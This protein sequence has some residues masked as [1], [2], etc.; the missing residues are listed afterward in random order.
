MKRFFG[1]FV[2]I[3][4]LLSFVV[5]SDNVTVY[6][7]YSS[8]CSHCANVA[9]SGVLEDVNSM[10]KVEVT[11]YNVLSEGRDKFFEFTDR[12]NLSR[13]VPLAVIEKDGN[14]SYLRGDSPI[15]NSLG[16]AVRG[17]GVD[18]GEEG[19]F[20]EI[21]SYLGKKF[22]ENFNSETGRLSFVGLL[23]LILAA[24]VDSINPCAFGVLIFLMICLLNLGSSKRALRYGLI[25][26]FVVFLVYFIAGF[27]VF[28][29][30]QSFSSITKLVYVLSGILVLGL[31]L[32]QF[33]D[34]FFPHIGPT[35]QIS[36]KAK[37]LIEKIIQMGTLPAMILLGIVVSLFELPCT[38]G[39]YLAIITLLSK[40][41][42]F[43]VLYL[44]IY[45]LIFI[46]PL[47]ILTSLIYKGTDA[48]ILQKWTQKE[49]KWMKFAAGIVLIALGLYIL[50]F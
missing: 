8:G 26:T 43:P 50:I 38:G 17:E 14:F 41:G 44:L 37:P 12:F 30:L 11:K 1:L 5:A 32:W 24:L 21:S 42:A 18:E 15:I 16:N 46:L 39:V 6:Y 48:H 31:G 22:E 20:S 9:S 2:L 49:R 10:D 23:I 7:F 28:H 29:A 45:N 27:G 19:F 35:L 13:G 36:P 34:V 3:V 47:I 33:K 40:S 4:F 25:Y